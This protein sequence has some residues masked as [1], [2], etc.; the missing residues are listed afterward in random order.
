MTPTG[1]FRVGRSYSSP[2]VPKRGA[3]MQLPPLLAIALWLTGATR[4]AGLLAYR[5]DQPPELV[6]GIFIVGIVAAVWSG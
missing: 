4:F 2:P 5:F 6:G 3:L 1:R